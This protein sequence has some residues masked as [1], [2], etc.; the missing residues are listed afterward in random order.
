MR[1]IFLFLR[2]YRTFFSFLLLQGVALWF[3]FTYNRTHRSKFLGFANEITGRVNSQYNQV[4]DFFHLREEN[5]RVNAFNDSLLNLLASNYGQR[6]TGYRLVTDT[7]PRDTVNRY[8]RY[9]SRPATVI[10]NTVS[11]QKNYIQL[12]RGARQGIRDNMAVIS[13]DGCAVGVVVNVSP[14]FSQ[15]MS[16]LHVQQKVNAAL[17][18]TGQ[19]GTLEWNGKD[20]GLLTLRGIPQS[21]PLQKGDTVLTSTYSFNFPPGYL[22]GYVEQIGKDKSTN[23]YTLGIR[24]AA[25]FLNLQQ[26]HVVENLERDEQVKL[27][28][29]TKQKMEQVKPKR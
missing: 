12:N 3:L 4:E 25:N 1:N 22:L 17:K 11:A 14:N 5:R 6:D 28:E 10:Y 8:R 7:L 9:V 24:P 15:V 2:R 16:L 21:V 23:F 20:P 29:D 19:F 18:K 13:S 27:Y 26:V